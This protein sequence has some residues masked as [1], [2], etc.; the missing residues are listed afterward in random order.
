MRLFVASR[1]GSLPD[2]LVW[3]CM[4]V[5][6]FSRRVFALGIFPFRVALAA[7]GF[8]WPFFFP[9]QHETPSWLRARPRKAIGERY[10][11]L[12]WLGWFQEPQRGEWGQGSI[13]AI[14]HHKPFADEPASKV[15]DIDRYAPVLVT[16]PACL[17]RGGRHRAKPSPTLAAMSSCSRC[18]WDWLLGAR[19]LSSKTVHRCSASTRAGLGVRDAARSQTVCFFL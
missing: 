15:Y 12:C 10:L 8:E 9:E 19:F 2:I 6:F 14:T 16:C 4:I 1:N 3:V 11:L 7:F 13:W 18:R 5:C 17:K